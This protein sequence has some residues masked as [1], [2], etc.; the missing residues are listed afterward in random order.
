MR[1]P[2]TEEDTG[3]N[4]VRVAI[5]SQTLDD[6]L[7][8]GD[9]G[10][11]PAVRDKLAINIDMKVNEIEYGHWN[12]PSLPVTRPITDS[13]IIGKFDGY[14]IQQIDD[15]YLILDDSN[16]YMGYIRVDDSSF[17]EAYVTPQNRRKGIASILI[18]FVLRDL[19]QQLIL[20]NDE[21][22]TDD[23]RQ[24]FFK[25][26]Q[27]NKIKISATSSLDLKHLLSIPELSKIFKD[28][29]D[30]DITLIIESEQKRISNTC[31]EIRNPNSNLAES[32]SDFGRT[33]IYYD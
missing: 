26:A 11:I 3:S 12:Q 22:I 21:M 10:S 29:S 2:V 20:S 30:N 1:F 27:A 7:G 6:S 19:K 13:K 9:A 28:I 5:Q 18:L 8:R 15:Y 23:S 24:L 25:L 4:P 17:R 14:D 31:F 32:N 33:V 16:Y